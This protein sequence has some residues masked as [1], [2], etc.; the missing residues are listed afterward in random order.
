MGLLSLPIFLLLDVIDVY[1]VRVAWD[2]KGP[3][4]DTRLGQRLSSLRVR[5]GSGTHP[6]ACPMGTEG[7]VVV[8]RQSVQVHHSP[9]S[10]SEVKY[11]WSYASILPCVFLAWCFKYRGR[12]KF[13]YEFFL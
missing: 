8:K 11:A 1:C 3:L 9:L 13:L 6:V 12:F 10:S 2:I 5:N 4:L 7:R